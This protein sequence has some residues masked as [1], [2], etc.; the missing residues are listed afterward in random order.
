MCRLA[1]GTQTG[2]SVIRPA[3]Y[4]GVIGYKPS[5]GEFTRVGIKMQCHSVDT[6]GLMARTIDDIALFRG[7]VLALPPV[8]DRSRRRGAAHRLL[9]HADL[10]RGRARHQGAAGEDRGQAVGQGRKV[11]DVAFAPAFDDILDDHGA[12]TGLGKPPAT[13]PTNGCAIP[14]R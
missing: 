9:P 4:C 2:G 8:R 7:A 10:G 13:M 3:A 14:T 11:V 1:F 12:I 5:F 6:L